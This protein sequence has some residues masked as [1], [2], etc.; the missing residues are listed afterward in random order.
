MTKYQDLKNELKIILEAEECQSCTSDSW[1]YRNDD[2]EPHRDI[3]NHPWEYYNKR[4]AVMLGVG[5]MVRVVGLGSQDPEFKSHLDVEL[6]PGG[7]DSAC[8]PSEIG[9]MSASLLMSCHSGDPSRIVP[10]RLLGQHLCSAEY[11]P[12]G[13]MDGT[14][15]TRCMTVCDSLLPNTAFNIFG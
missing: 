2:K 6:I 7:V 10:R 15:L 12:N 9:K 11:G 8:H 14:L 4:T 3:K 13:W 1:S 5:F